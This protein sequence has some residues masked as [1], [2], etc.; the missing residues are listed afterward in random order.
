MINVIWKYKLEVDVAPWLVKE[1]NGMPASIEIPK[2]AEF[3]H[4]EAQ[5][6]IAL[7]YKVDPNNEKEKKTFKIY[8][9]GK[10]IDMLGFS[11][12][13]GT[14]QYIEASL[15]N[16]AVVLVWHIFEVWQ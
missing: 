10:P 8:P 1:E 7:W 16:T 13:L 2:G 9:T 15:D 14:C 5:N 12:Y 6:G 11:K 3:L 4:I